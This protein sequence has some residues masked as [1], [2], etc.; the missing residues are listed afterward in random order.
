[1]NGAACTSCR[2]RTSERRRRRR[3]SR[4]VRAS[5]MIPRRP[6]RRS[7]CRICP[8][9]TALW[10]PRGRAS[11]CRLGCRRPRVRSAPYRHS[12]PAMRSELATT[13]CTPRSQIWRRRWRPGTVGR[14]A[15]FTRL[16]SRTSARTRGP[17]GSEAASRRFAPHA[18]ALPLPTS[19]ALSYHAL[20]GCSHIAR[21]C[22]DTRR[23]SGARRTRLRSCLAV[24]CNGARPRCPY[25]TRE[26][27]PRRTRPRRRRRDDRRFGCSSS[28]CCRLTTHCTL[29]HLR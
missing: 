17:R 4:S 29:S 13:S 3:Q 26:R 7:S 20:L 10:R 6:G 14:R 19:H 12:A 18:G 27:R 1:M 28:C 24:S 16:P 22:P 8:W 15:T 9:A 5:P 21:V 11:H 2:C 23:V 25:P